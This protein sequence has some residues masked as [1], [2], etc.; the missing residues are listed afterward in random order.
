MKQELNKSY[1]EDRYRHLD[2]PWDLG[3]PAPWIF[4]IVRNQLL[5]PHHRILVP[6]AGNGHEVVWLWQHGFRN[7]TVIDIARQPLDKIRQ[8]LP[9][10]PSEQLVEDD[11]FN[12]YSR[13]DR[14]LEQTFFCAINPEL[15][16]RYV[17]HMA[18]LLIDKGILTGVL[19]DFPLTEKGPPFGGSASE[20]T[21]RF[22]ELFH[23]KE[24]GPCLYSAPGRMGK[25]LFA[26]F[27]KK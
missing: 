24:L 4:E 14:I 3:N 17:A 10:F 1:W 25:E 16:D 18:A 27:E 22:S 11:F 8:V 2:I 19:F 12:H 6:G 26:I 9:E 5:L 23:I 20:Y 13:Y 21:E 7:I 15:R